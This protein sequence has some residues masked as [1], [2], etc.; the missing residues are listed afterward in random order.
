MST[1]QGHCLDADTV[2]LALDI[3]VEAEKIAEVGD[4]VI[5]SVP[6]ELWQQFT[7]E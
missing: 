7:G 1:V 3:L 6:V 5:L 2:E 4:N